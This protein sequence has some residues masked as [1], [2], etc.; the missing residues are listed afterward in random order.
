ME[1]TVRLREGTAQLTPEE[2]TRTSAEGGLPCCHFD[3]GSSLLQSLRAG[4]GSRMWRRGKGGIS[5]PAAAAVK[6]VL[7]P[8]GPVPGR[9]GGSDGIPLFS[10]PNDKIFPAIHFASIGI[11]YP[12]FG[13]R[14]D[15]RCVPTQRTYLSIICFLFGSGAQAPGVLAA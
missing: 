5:T 11:S 4:E 8:L 9:G 3:N 15:L 10:P 13:S 12:A 1:R 14:S 7:G 6:L 2:D